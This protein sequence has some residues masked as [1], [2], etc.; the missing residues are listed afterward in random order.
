[1]QRLPDDELLREPAGQVAVAEPAAHRGR[2]KETGQGLTAWRIEGTLREFPKFSA[3]NA[4]FSYPV[5]QMDTV[6][7]L[8]DIQPEAEMPPWKKGAAKN[9][10]SAAERKKERKKS[11]EDAIENGNFGDDPA[12]KD[13]ASY[14]GIAERS[15][16]DG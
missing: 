12:V 14:L 13:V 6:G 4:W 11:L 15:V 16:R 7:V 8:G 1:M 2:G 3:V 10:Q 5:H 9:K